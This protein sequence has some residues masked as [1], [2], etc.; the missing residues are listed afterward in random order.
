MLLCS[1]VS[2]RKL[3]RSSVLDQD[4]TGLLLSK[5][6][7]KFGYNGAL[8]THK[9]SEI[10]S[11]GL[12][13]CAVLDALHLCWCRELGT[14]IDMTA[15]SVVL[16]MTLKE[17]LHVTGDPDKV[18][19]HITNSFHVD[20][21]ETLEA[22]QAKCNVC[23]KWFASI[24]KHRNRTKDDPAHL[25][26]I[27]YGIKPQLCIPLFQPGSKQSLMVQKSFFMPL[28]PKPKHRCKGLPPPDIVDPTSILTPPS[29]R[30]KPLATPA[31]VH[32]LGWDQYLSRIEN[33]PTIFLSFHD[34]AGL[35]SRKLRASFGPKTPQ[36]KLESFLQRLPKAVTNYLLHAVMRL[37]GA[38]QATISLVTEGYDCFLCSCSA[39]NGIL[40]YQ[41]NF[42]PPG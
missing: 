26:K 38:H 31:Y 42:L 16:G 25:N 18:L 10:S 15:K 36:F 7:G 41:R 34:L 11:S 39:A 30:S 37:R 17:F 2:V 32:R 8:C 1:Q 5:G 9:P 4:L 35:T 28:D 14:L 19:K 20:L 3:P 27:G 23:E 12:G 21:S 29:N 40:Q 13:T 22:L 33:D 6:T 24:P